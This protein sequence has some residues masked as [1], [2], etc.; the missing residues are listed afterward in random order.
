MKFK[1]GVI[2]VG[3][4]LWEDTP[5]RVN[6]RNLCL[7][8]KQKIP[9]SIPIRYGRKS[10]SRKNTYTM[11]FSN[12]PSTVLGQAFIIPLKEEIKNYSVLEKNA[13][14]MAK[15]EG[16]WKNNDLVPSINKPWGTVGLL[17]NPKNDRKDNINADL[18]RNSWQQI[19]QT[20][21]NSF[22][23][24]TYNIGADDVPLIDQDGFLQIP[25]TEQ[26]NDFDFLLATPTVPNPHKILSASEIAEKMNV[27]GYWSYFTKNASHGITTFQDE[28][29][30]QLL[31]QKPHKV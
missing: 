25:W 16:I 23:P 21:H 27:T 31:S 15:A 5:E 18:I 9:V 6:W 17:L 2:I 28:E 11:I 26:M 22:N 24:S 8:I 29:I 12:H 10:A 19:Y 1:G 3:S 20:Y 4:L 13:F 30:L 14:A 7:R